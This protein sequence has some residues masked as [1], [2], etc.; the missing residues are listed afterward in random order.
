MNF[1]PGSFRITGGFQHQIQISFLPQ[2]SKK[3]N[4][5]YCVLLEYLHR[6]ASHQQ[7]Y[8]HDRST[9]LNQNETNSTINAAQPKEDTA[10][11]FTNVFQISESQFQRSFHW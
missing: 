1:P 9:L 6:G 11:I 10:V 8:T 4:E 5:N 3:I 7:T 2:K